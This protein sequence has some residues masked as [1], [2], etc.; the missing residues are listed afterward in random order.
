M[1]LEKLVVRKM[2]EE[3]ASGVA[4]VEAKCF[5]TPW[6]EVEF[7]KAASDKNYTFLVADI[8]GSIIGMAGL[9][10]SIPEATVTN[11]AVVPEY[12]KCGIARNV[13]SKLLDI[14]GEEGVTEF[15][16]EVRESNA[17][18]IRLYESLGFSFEGKRPRF[19]ENPVE[20]ALI[21]WKR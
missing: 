21:Y 16:L 4:A 20:G 5:S 10:K 3:D 18:A 15:T 14:G 2:T 7:F 8:D 19:Y 9:I 6:P 11:V 13:V 1:D 17:G 12:R